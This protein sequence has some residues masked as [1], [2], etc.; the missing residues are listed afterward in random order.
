M[1]KQEYCF[2]K[3]HY[4]QFNALC[5]LRRSTGGGAAKKVL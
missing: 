1:V 4:D 5:I 2:V 3:A